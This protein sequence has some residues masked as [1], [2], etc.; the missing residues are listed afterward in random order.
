MNEAALKSLLEQVQQGARSIDDAVEQLRHLPF[1]DLG[2]AVDRSPPDACV[3]VS[4]K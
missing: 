1:E 4:R 2:D 3:R